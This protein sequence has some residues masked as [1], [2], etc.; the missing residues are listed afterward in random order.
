MS[1]EALKARQGEEWAALAVFLAPDHAAAAREL[2]R[3]CRAGGRL[4]LGAC[5]P[6]GRPSACTRTTGLQRRASTPSTVRSPSSTA[7]PSS[8]TTSATA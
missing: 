8:P 7:A 2:A 3:V 1:F 5:V 4:G 6:I